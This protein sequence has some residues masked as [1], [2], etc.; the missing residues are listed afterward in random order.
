MNQTETKSVGQRVL[1]ALGWRYNK[2]DGSNTCEQD[3][4]PEQAMAAI[5]REVGEERDVGKINVLVKALE[6]ITD[7]AGNLPDDRLTDRTGPND[8]A[9][10]G[11]LVCNARNIA[12]FAL[13]NF[14]K[15]TS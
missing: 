15:E 10:R 4:T 5:E 14:Q 3:M 11:Q 13:E 7:V 8:A 12:H 1:E 2:Y 9:Y 6:A